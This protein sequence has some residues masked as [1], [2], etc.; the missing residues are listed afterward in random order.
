MTNKQRMTG[1]TPWRLSRYMCIKTITKKNDSKTFQNSDRLPSGSSATLETMDEMKP[2][3][4]SKD[5]KSA[6]NADHR[7]VFI[8]HFNLRP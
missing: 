3:N 2:T 5:T 7:V 1:T 4:I 6:K 8:P